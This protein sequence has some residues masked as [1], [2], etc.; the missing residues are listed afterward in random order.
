MPLR[1]AE[2]S[3]H[4]DRFIEDAV[5]SGRF[6]DASEV[7]NEGLRLL[8]ERE[9]VNREKR[10]WLR[11]AAKEGFD[12][13]DRGEGIE[14]ESMAELTAYIDELEGE[15]AAAVAAERQCG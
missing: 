4:L 15:V 3:V 2:V 6:H 13:I 9:Q 10:E 8:R 12:A 1:S 14:F 5:A 11:A 7:V